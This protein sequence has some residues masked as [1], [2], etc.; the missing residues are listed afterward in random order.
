MTT[1]HPI[2][3][4]APRDTAA[5]L[6]PLLLQR[7]DEDFIE[8][9]LD[10]LRTAAGRQALQS[11]RATATDANGTRKLFQPIQ[12]Q[13]HLAVLEAWCDLPG[14]P[15][16]DPAQVDTAGLC[17]RRLGDGGAQEGWMRSKGRVRGWVPL[18][19]VGGRDVPPAPDARLQQGLTGVGSIDRELVALQRQRADSLLSEHV[20]PLYLAPPDVCAEAG[21]TLFYGVVPT[22]SSELSEAP[23][24]LSSPAADDFLNPQSAAFQG[25]L[26]EALRGEAMELPFPGQAVRAGWFDASEMPGDGAPN[27]V[28]ADQW[29]Q[30]QDKDSN[31]S[32][33][34]AR[35]ILLLRQLGAEFNAFEGGAEVASLKALFAQ[36]QL[37]LVLRENE[38]EE[39]RRFV[40]AEVFLAQASAVL[41]DKQVL[42]F[43]VEVPEVWPAQDGAALAAALGTAMQAR[44]A[45][46]K[47]RAG[48]FDEPQARYVIRAFVR[49]KAEAA[50]PARTV[51]SDDSEPFVIAPWYEGA[52]AP[53]VQIRL[54]DPSD[55]AAMKALKPSV[56]FVVPPSLQNLLSGRVKDLMEG[57]GST[58]TGGLGITWICG[59][60]IP[61]ITI[62]AFIV[63]NI[64]FSLFN[65][66]FGW[67][68]LLKICVP[69]PNIG[70]KL[71]PELPPP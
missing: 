7:S 29:G 13:F 64:F 8:S 46:M 58:R 14:L 47:G 16:I 57:K 70:N 15:R 45:S 11:L 32:R 24:T 36:M 61:L 6:R 20:I 44:F 69:F 27:G 37:P 31:D 59:F 18:N 65:L 26:V 9:T 48:R 43:D 60:N 33:R 71:P 12:R 41:L 63:L 21:K 50:C 68:F 51:W 17:L 3:L 35:F 56:A 62:C 2:A 1:H 30:L 55:R 34:L 40:A 52:G 38:T 22:V 23:P 53:P 28:S 54:P 67:I 5:G 39:D 42:G 19:R 10:D 4:G 25:H 49:L 66:V